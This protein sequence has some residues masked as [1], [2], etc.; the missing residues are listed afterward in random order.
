MLAALHLVQ[1]I[2]RG[3]EEIGIGGQ[4]FAVEIKL[5]DGLATVECGQLSMQTAGGEP[6][7]DE[8]H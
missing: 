8:A 2:A 5:H 1:R 7:R 6:I 4:D 3:I